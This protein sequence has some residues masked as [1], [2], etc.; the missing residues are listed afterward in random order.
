MTSLHEKPDTISKHEP[1]WGVWYI[2]S[3][4]GEGSFGK[5][6]KIRRQEFGKTYYSAVK[7][8]SIP[9]HD[10]EIRQMKQEGLNEESIRMFY[11]SLAKSIIS[12]IN[13]MNEFSGNSN[14]V[15]YED[16]QI[17][18]QTNTIGW[19]ILIRMELLQGM[20]RAQAPLTETEVVR[21]GIHICCALELCA[22]KNIIHRDIKPENI[23]VSQYGDYK[24]GDFGVA[25]H[26]IDNV[27]G[28]SKKGTYSYMAP[29][30]FKGDKYGASIDTYS[31]GIVLYSFLNQNRIPFLPDYPHSILPSDRESA[32]SRRMSGEPIPY[33]KGVSLELSF[34][35]L[36]ACAYNSQERFASPTEMREA[37]EAVEKQ[38]AAR[39]AP[40]AIGVPSPIN[41]AAYKT[42]KETHPSN[43]S[44]GTRPQDSTI[45]LGFKQE[46]RRGEGI[47]AA[48]SGT[49]ILQAS[50][51]QP[52]S[53]ADSSLSR[54][55]DAATLMLTDCL[56]GQLTDILPGQESA[57]SGAVSADAPVPERQAG[58]PAGKL[59]GKSGSRMAMRRK[60][61]LSSFAALGFVLVVAISWIVYSAGNTPGLAEDP[62]PVSKEPVRIELKD[63]ALTSEDLASL[64]ASGEIPE[65]VTFLDISG[66]QISDISS[67]QSL[68]KLESLFLQNNQISDTTPLEVLAELKI[69]NL[70]SN[71]I[72]DITPF[73]SMSNL[74]SLGL[75]INRDLAKELQLA[76]PQCNIF[77]VWW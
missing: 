60:A 67:L 2:E 13:M 63:Q 46:A 28:L 65:D 31:L 48:Y 1:L 34:L 26:T 33:L 12:E 27:S 35:V 40:F 15:S 11:Q 72:T 41:K 16:H 68:S 54:T 69:L 70:I 5:V 24:L 14:I 6:Y 3:L 66:N 7:F 75:L 57:N 20:D 58:K 37:L 19:D 29:E 39:G 61:F 49:S 76:L 64:I 38:L 53:R 74:E 21:L 56:P 22:Q 71:P 55:G 4:I 50:P 43:P 23:F 42:I 62:L 47:E 77:G 36:K 30:V 9:Q 45:T 52:P 32:L 8:I 44:Q 10:S 51:K 17:I 18:E 73:K 25:R 59:N